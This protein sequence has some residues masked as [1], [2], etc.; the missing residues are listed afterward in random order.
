[1]LSLQ[2]LI[3]E[4]IEDVRLGSRDDGS[5]YPIQAMNAAKQV[6]ARHNLSSLGIQEHLY[7]QMILM[8]NDRRIRRDA[9]HLASTSLVDFIAEAAKQEMGDEY[10]RLLQGRLDALSPA[11]TAY[12]E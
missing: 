10:E 1:M 7:W 3:D 12:A 11:K 6:L 4:T 9:Q 2:D 5:P 8:Q